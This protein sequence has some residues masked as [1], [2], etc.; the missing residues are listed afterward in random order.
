M[1]EPDYT[2][3]VFQAGVDK[4]LNLG[5][6]TNEIARMYGEV[7]C[8]PELGHGS[9]EDLLVELEAACDSHWAIAGV[10]VNQASEALGYGALSFVDVK[11]GQV[12]LDSAYVRPEDRRRGVYKGLFQRRLEIAQQ[13]GAT[14]VTTQPLPDANHIPYLVREGFQPVQGKDC[15]IYKRKL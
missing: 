4:Q 1:K 14:E 10:A 13:L 9:E 12:E 7:L 2:Y 6:Y 15:V 8:L 5:K 3:E 11:T